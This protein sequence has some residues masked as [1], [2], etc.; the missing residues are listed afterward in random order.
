MPEETELAGE[1]RVGVDKGGP[2]PAVPGDEGLGL[3]EIVGDVEADELVLRV[4][5]DEARVGDRLAVADRSP[6]GPDVDVDGLPAQ[7]G[8]REPLPR[9]RLAL[10]SRAGTF[11]PGG[12]AGG[13]SVTAG[14]ASPAPRYGREHD[15]EKSQSRHRP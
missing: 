8:E 11:G 3:V 10:E 12:R 14:V 7:V 4:I 5:L 13:H 1:L 2:R 9:Q 15:D 6:R